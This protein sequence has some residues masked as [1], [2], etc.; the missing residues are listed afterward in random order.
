NGSYVG[1]SWN[2]IYD[3][4]N[5]DIECDSHEYVETVI[6]PTCTTGG[7][8][9]Y[10]CEVCGDTFTSD[11]TDSLGHNYKTT[12]TK[13]TT[14]KNGS[15]VTKC[16]VCGDIKSSTTIAKIKSAELS[17]TT[18]TYTGKLLKPEVTVKDSNGNKIA[19]SNYTVTYN[20]NK[21]VGKATVTIKFKGNYS[22]TI[23]RTF[24]IKPKASRISKLTAKSRGF[25]VTW[26][27]IS[28]Q[29]TGYK[30]QYSTSKKFTKKTTVTKTVKKSK[31]RLTLKK[32]K[33]N[34]KYYVRICTY[35]KVN[36]VR[37]YSS[38]SKAKPVKTKK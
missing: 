31:T 15:I 26:K 13:A 7:Y 11:H 9:K 25:R 32:L 6:K 14:S 2:Y 12:I 3:K 5:T 17:K 10:I 23:T 21:S 8:T 24:T 34:K 36:G 19:S 35:K 20:N 1:T 37:Y 28:S 38:W 22:G 18:Y 27:K 30:I 29:I 16:S 4:E 33:A